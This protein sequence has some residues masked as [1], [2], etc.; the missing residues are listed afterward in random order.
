MRRHALPKLLVIAGVLT[1]PVAAQQSSD[2]QV[3]DNISPAPALVQPLP[4]S[5]KTHLGSGLTC[6]NCHV[7]GDPGTKMGFPETRN[8]MLC[9][10]A[11]ATDKPGVKD[12]LAYSTSGQPIPWVRVYK[13]AST[14]TWG[15][16][17]HLDAGLQCETCH[18]DVRQM[19][20]MAETKATRA[21]ATCIGC[22]QTQGAPAECVS[23]HAWPTDKMLGIE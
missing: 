14:V 22:H 5:H 4:F 9:H 18:G 15:H 23:C 6:M 1:I 21:M 13:I 17:V 2:Y 11:L 8:C 20:A 10:A 16:R 7:N 3:P 12:L 19:E